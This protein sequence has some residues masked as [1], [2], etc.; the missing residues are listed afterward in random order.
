MNILVV[1][2]G[3]YGTVVARKLAERGADVTI[4]DKR[5]HIAGNCYSECVNKIYVHKYGPHAFHTNNKKIWDFVSSFAEF[6][7]FKLKVLVNKNEN[8]YSFPINLL[9]LNQVLGISNYIDAIKFLESCKKNEISNNFKEFVVNN[10]GKELYE[11][12]YEGYTKKQWNKN[13]EDLPASIAKR[14]PVR[15]NFYDYYFE[16]K[17]QGIPIDGYTNLFENMLDHQNIKIILN[18]D[19]FI[20]KKELENN[21][22]FVFYSGKI[23]EFFE[24]RHGLLE[25]R[26]LRFEEKELCHTLQGN[27]QIN[28]ADISIPYT[29]IVEHKY[30]HDQTIKN[31]VVTYEYPDDYDI[32]KIP[33]YPIE[34]E[35]NKQIYCKYQELASLESKYI[36]GGRLGRYTYLNMD[37]VIGMAFNDVEKLYVR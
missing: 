2:C 16:D 20:N 6:N 35:Y 25:Y 34:S 10:V 1:G 5:S 32:G 30:F 11:I 9:T 33:Y 18:T 31:S 21:F 8:I 3:M 37:Q 24:Y 19:F 7:D 12:F 27:A 36:F 29:R 4:I 26:S 15:L 28:Y 14:I 22:D 17:Y 23:D 13:P